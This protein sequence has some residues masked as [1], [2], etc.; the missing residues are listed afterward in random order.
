M[1]FALDEN[2]RRIKARPD[3]TAICPCCSSIV[4]SKC[5]QINEWHWAHQTIDDCD[6]WHEPESEWHKGWK[7]YWGEQY[8]EKVIGRHRA[9][10]FYK[11]IVIELQNSHISPAEIREREDFYGQMIWIF[12]SQSFSDNFDLRPHGNYYSFRWKHPRKSIW[13]CEKPVLFDL[14]YC[15][16]WPKKIYHEVPCGGWGTLIHPKVLLDENFL[17]RIQPPIIQ[18]RL[19]SEKYVLTN[20]SFIGLK[21]TFKQDINMG[22]TAQPEEFGEWLDRGGLKEFK[23]RI[24]I[25][26]D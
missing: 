13:A 18:Q 19:S 5:G 22:F 12:K 24:A 16:F 21:R 1:I 10:V 25:D 4:I 7:A 15:L 17:K 3:S 11:D 2:K 20:P 8:C 23:D 9:D 26:R 14:G 6:N